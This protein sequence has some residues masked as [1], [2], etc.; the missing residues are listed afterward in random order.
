MDKFLDFTTGKIIMGNLD[1]K[2]K[3]LEVKTLTASEGEITL[4]PKLTSDSEA[5]GTMFYCSTD[6]A[7]YVGTE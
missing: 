1:I 5:E 7:I 2:S 6:N 3:H 4:T